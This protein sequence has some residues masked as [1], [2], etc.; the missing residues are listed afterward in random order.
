MSSQRDYFRD[1]AQVPH[2]QDKETGFVES[3]PPC[4]SPA[5]NIPRI[6]EKGN[7]ATWLKVFEI[8]CI[9]LIVLVTVGLLLPATQRMSGG[10]AR[11]SCANN[12]KQ[13]GVALGNYATV[14][15]NKLPPQSM[16]HPVNQEGWS[17]FFYT[18]LPFVEYFAIYKRSIGCGGC[19]TNGNNS[20][21]VKTFLCP[22]DSTHAN[23]LG[24]NGWAVT[25]YS[26]NAL[27]FA[28]TTITD[29]VTGRDICQAKYQIH[30]IPDGAANT[31]ALVER[32]GT[33][34]ASGYSSLWAAPC[35]GEWGWPETSH[36]Y[37]MWSTGRPELNVPASSAR[38]DLPS[39]PHPG[40]VQVLM[41]DG[42][43]RPVRAT[44]SAAAWLAALTPNDG[45]DLTVNW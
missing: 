25:S 27:L 16:Y 45:E 11:M 1:E 34:P 43:V 26:D 21:V 19:W 9:T 3:L 18:T 4:P 15:S 30:N 12:L 7:P 36:A 17:S 2:R 32:V 31:I 8:G 40:L 22:S 6:K 23:G 29:P 28:S 41:M 13:L 35:G 38:Y 44:V 42:C 20:T 33:F 14:Y 39:S 37:G 10:G 24:S 5:E